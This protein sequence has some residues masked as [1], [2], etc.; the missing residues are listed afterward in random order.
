MKGGGSRIADFL[1]RPA[2]TSSRLIV[3]VIGLQ[4]DTKQIW[5][6]FPSASQPVRLFAFHNGN[7]KLYDSEP[8][9]S[10]SLVYF[11]CTLEKPSTSTTH[12][13]HNR[14]S[15]PGV[16]ELAVWLA[17]SVSVLSLSEWARRVLG[18]IEKDRDR[19]RS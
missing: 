1:K 13:G 14:V 5:P 18:R 15:L 6:A 12:A 11:C 3:A 17:L 8:A 2:A 16:V 9:G 19:G 10:R 4:L 7:K